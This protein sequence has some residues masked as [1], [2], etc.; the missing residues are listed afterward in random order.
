MIAHTKG[1]PLGER[2]V[3][4][5]MTVVASCASSRY[6]DVVLQTESAQERQLFC[7]PAFSNGEREQDGEAARLGDELCNGLLLR[8]VYGGTQGDV[9]MLRCAARFWRARLGSADSDRWLSSLREMPSGENW[10]QIA[11]RI[12]E[13]DCFLPEGADFHCFP[14]IVREIAR[15]CGGGLDSEQVRRSIWFW[16][17]SRTT[18]LLLSDPKNV[19]SFSAEGFADPERELGV[20]Q[21]QATWNRVREEFQLVAQ[22]LVLEIRAP[23]GE[24][25]SVGDAAFP[26]KRKADAAPPKARSPARPKKRSSPGPADSKQQTS[27]LNFFSYKRPTTE[28]VSTTNA[29]ERSKELL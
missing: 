27:L 5:L 2:D 25:D 16:S 11:S 24:R 14:G 3:D 15:K 7:R 29:Q 4:L 21:T 8:A 12:S 23:R 13:T 17:S 26:G 6:R 28:K 22:R 20:L 10:R 19:S 18:K 9:S 1:R